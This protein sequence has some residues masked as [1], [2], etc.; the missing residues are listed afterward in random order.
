M[1]VYGR[2]GCTIEGVSRFETRSDGVT[3]GLRSQ[4]SVLESQHVAS[5]SRR[6]RVDSGA[7][8]WCG[9]APQVLNIGS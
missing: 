3:I 2:C 4:A 6:G 8:G 9:V 5:P 1:I 7:V